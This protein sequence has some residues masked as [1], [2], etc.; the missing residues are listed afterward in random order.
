M[1]IAVLIGVGIV[2]LAHTAPA[3]FVLDGLAGDRAVWHMPRTAPS[4][5]Y[6][7]Y[8]DGPNPT[9]TPGLLDVLA[10]EHVSAT[11]FVIDRHLTVETAPIVSR[12]F[13]EGHAVALHSA[14]R[15]EMLLPPSVLARELTAAADRMEALTGS[16]PCRV[17]RPHGGWRSGSMY[18][19][20]RRIDY[21]LVG[22]GW[23]LWDVDWFRPRTADRI[24][25]RL[26][27]RAAAGDIVVMH[28]G[29]ESAPTK[30]QPHTVEA[31]AR[32][33]AHLRAKGLG[34]GTVCRNELAG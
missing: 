5:V 18:I 25:A 34:F 1:W 14:S 23:M 8:D 10:R 16:R 13:A 22:W 7:T 20:L 29:D 12:M 2:V 33:I 32:L 3:P 30:P 4:T 17:F 15:R 9:T 21:R 31:T 6:L 26:A 19:A 28:D 24:V 11:F 27:A